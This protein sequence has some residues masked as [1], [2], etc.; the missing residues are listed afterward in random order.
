M[1]TGSLHTLLPF[2]VTLSL[3]CAADPARREVPRGR[4]GVVHPAVCTGAPL[5]DS[6]TPSREG[7]FREVLFAAP[8]PRTSR[9]DDYTPGCYHADKLDLARGLPTEAARCGA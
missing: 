6:V 4:P 5:P 7:F 2:V 1:R 3:A 8:T 9:Y